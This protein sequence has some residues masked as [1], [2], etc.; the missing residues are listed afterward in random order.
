[1][2]S[3]AGLV[4]RTGGTYGG[5]MAVRPVV[6]WPDERLRQ[7]SVAIA[8]VDASVRALYQDL[9]DSMYAENG[10]PSIPPERLRRYGA[11]PRK[12][13]QYPGLKEEYYLADFEPDESVLGELQIVR[14]IRE[15]VRRWWGIEPALVIAVGVVVVAVVL[16]LGFVTPGW[17]NKKVFDN[18][19]VQG[20]VKQVL[21]SGHQ[22][23]NVSC[24]AGKP[25][26]AGT[27]FTCTATVDGQKKN[28]VIT[29]KDD[30][31]KY[32]VAQPS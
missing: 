3:A 7:P 2:A 23:D 31:G 32:E 25:V 18:V 28:I 14:K 26:K 29:V 17:F 27:T 1:M 24:P 22:I 12:L 20:G 8:A 15:T 19:A 4:N 30:N 6:I 10:R 11:G 5:T 13:R 9:V 21:S 16:V